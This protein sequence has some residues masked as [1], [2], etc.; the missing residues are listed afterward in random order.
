MCCTVQISDLTN[1]AET[2][3]MQWLLEVHPF[4]TN[5]LG[6]LRNVSNWAILDHFTTSQLMLL[7]VNTVYL[8][9]HIYMYI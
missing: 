7:I 8:S 5:Y 2:T 6:P 9:M 3:I 1:Y 4:Q